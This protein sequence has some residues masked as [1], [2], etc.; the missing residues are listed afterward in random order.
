MNKVFLIGNL[1]RDPELTTTSSGVYACRFTLAVSRPYMNANN[2]RETDFINIV[3]WRNLAESCSKYLIKGS[4]IAVCGELQIRTYDAQDGSKRYSTEIVAEDVEFLTPRREEPAKPQT[5]RQ[6]KQVKLS[7][8]K[9][10]ED[11]NEFPF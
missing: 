8:L 3:T 6:E 10:V 4:K 2:E 5:T 1:T 7:E 9:P 11:D